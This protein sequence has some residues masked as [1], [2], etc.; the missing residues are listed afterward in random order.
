MMIWSS[1]R[2][3]C[4]ASSVGFE[5]GK[6]HAL[7]DDLPRAGQA[8][9]AVRVFLHLAHDQFL[10]ERPAID[11][12]A[13]GL[14]MVA[15][16]SADGGELLVAALACADISRVDAVFVERLGRA[17]NFVKRDV[18]VVVE[19]ADER[20]IAAGVEHALLDFGHGRS[21]FRDID[22]D[23]HHLRTG[24]GQLDALPR[25]A[26]HVDGIRIRHGL[27]GDGCAAAHL[28]S[29]DLHRVPFCAVPPC[30]FAPRLTA[31]D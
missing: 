18:A 16:H 21:R 1:R 24:G 9:N 27:N 15:G 29:P 2:P 23:P 4:S 12:D 30:R 22:R 20:S 6:H 8:E 28:D 13:H 5:R 26:R 7:V 14:A 19:V 3:H 31:M 17:G 11:A 25:G 10:I